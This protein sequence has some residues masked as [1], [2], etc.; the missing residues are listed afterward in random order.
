[1]DEF[2]I[3]AG[4]VFNVDL[5][6]SKTRRCAPSNSIVSYRN[7]FMQ[8][9]PNPETIEAESIAILTGI[10]ARMDVEESERDQQQKETA[11]GTREGRAR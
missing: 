9:I 3:R 2:G 8:T 7:S 1:M 6:D 11:M 4:N 5:K 10:S